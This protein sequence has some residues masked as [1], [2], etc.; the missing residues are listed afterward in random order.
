MMHHRTFL[1]T[2]RRAALLLPMTAPLAAALLWCFLP[3]HAQELPVA[4]GFTAHEW[5]TFT[6]IAGPDGKAIDW[7]PLS[8]STDLPSFVEHLKANNFKLGLAGKVRMETPVIYFYSAEERNISVQVSFAKG[9]I[10]EWYPHAKATPLV[11]NPSA[12]AGGQNKDGRIRWDSVQIEPHSA[13]SFATETQASH[14]YAARETS[15]TPLRVSSP[16]GEQAE[17]FLFY[18]GVSDV[19]VPISATVTA[20]GSIKLDTVGSTEI[21]NAILFEKRGGKIGYRV[22]GPVR[23]QGTYALPELSNAPNAL[24][25]DLEGE[26]V[27]QGLYTDE[28]HAMVQTWKDSWF[29]EGA[30]LFYIVPR[31]FVDSVLP[32]TVTP[33]PVATTRVF[34]GRIELVTPE[35]Q[36]AVES[37]FTTNDQAKLAEYGRFLE[38]ILRIMMQSST[39]P[40]RTQRL[41]GYLNSV[42]GEL[43]IQARNSS[44]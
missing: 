37:A 40:E 35:T 16:S 1:R 34:V 8:N 25:S 39:D 27:A 30:R 13:A 36:R 32:L 2:C 14:Y 6:S 42:Y 18:R 29:G 11:H 12:A 44:Q 21:P 41:E 3:S 7:F 9:W 19:D 10:T 15:S 43:I 33:S 17:R 4:S 26:L 24:L 20:D 38:P 22:L 31:T 23:D 5:G 28:A